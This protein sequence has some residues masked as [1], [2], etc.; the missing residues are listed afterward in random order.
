M[1]NA[2]HTNPNMAPAS[3]TSSRRGARGARTA[4]AGP[5][6]DRRIEREIFG[7]SL[8]AARRFYSVDDGAAQ[9]VIERVQERIPGAK[10]RCLLD[11]DGYRCEWVLPSEGRNNARGSIVSATANSSALAVCLASLKAS[12]LGG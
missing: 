7:L 9:S 2:L 4:E 1:A 11:S 10:V 8:P 12:A 6:V 3:L 5:E